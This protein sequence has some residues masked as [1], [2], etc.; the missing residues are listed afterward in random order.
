MDTW[1]PSTCPHPNEGNNT[2]LRPSRRPWRWKHWRTLVAGVPPPKTP[3][4]FLVLTSCCV[5]SGQLLGC[6]HVCE[7]KW[8]SGKE[9]V[10]CINVN[11][12]SI[13]QKLDAGT[14]VL[15]LTGN[16]LHTI[17]R[18]AFHDAGLINLQKVYL[19]KCRLKTLDRYAFRKLINLVELD[20]SYNLLAAVPSHIFDSISELRELKLSGNPIQRILN[21]AFIHVPQL[22]RLEL[23]SCRI[24]TI[25]PRAFNGLEHTL[26]WLK[27][28]H[29]RLVDMKPGTV[30]AMRNLHGLELAGNLWNCTC[31][32]RPLREWMLR[33]NIPYDVPPVCRYPSRLAEKAWDKLDLDEFAC[34]PK[35][36]AP[37]SLTTGVEGRNVTM[38]CEIGGIPEPKVKWL[39][40]NRV[41]ANLSTGVPY[42]GGR[43]LYM[44]HVAEKES[45]LTILTA[46]IQDEGM[47]VCTA[48]NK[49]GKA[50]ASVTLAVL[51]RPPEGSV[52]GKVLVAS[53]IVAA[54]FVL[55]SCLVVLCVCGV[56]RRQQAQGGMVVGSS[57]LVR[58]G[59]GRGRD[60]SYEKIEMNHKAPTVLN[61]TGVNEGAGRCGSLPR[62]GGSNSHLGPGSNSEVAVVGP[63]MVMRQH[64]RHSEYRGVPSVDTDVGDGDGDDEDEEGEDDVDTPTPTTVL[65]GARESKLWGGVRSSTDSGCS[66]RNSE[67]SDIRSPCLPETDLHIPRISEYVDRRDDLAASRTVTGNGLSSLGRQRLEA[68]NPRALHEVTTSTGVSSISCTATLRP[69]DL[70]SPP[71]L[72]HHVMRKQAVGNNGGS[73]YTS[74]LP[75][76]DNTHPDKNYP[77]LLEISPYNLGSASGASANVGGASINMTDGSFCTLPRRRG[78]FE[79]AGVRGSARYYRGAGSDSQ[80]PLLPDSRYGSSGGEGSGGSNGSIRR[81]SIDSYSSS[82]YPLST[83]GTVHKR[84]GIASQRS[85][86]SLNLASPGA[87]SV[88]MESS[89]GIPSRSRKNPSLPTS[90]VHEH[91]QVSTPTTSAT[92]LLNLMGS[93]TRAGDLLRDNLYS[94]PTTVSSAN[95]NTYDYHAAQLERFLEEYRSLQEQLCKMKETCEN[96]RQDPPSSRHPPSS[97]S[98]YTDPLLFGGDNVSTPSGSEDSNNPK[99]ILKNKSSTVAVTATSASS[100]MGGA[101]PGATSPLGLTSGGAVDYGTDLPPYWLPRN[102]LLRRF[103]GGDFFQS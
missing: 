17:P 5:V 73:M 80:S 30:T 23:S 38:S 66:N 69:G 37:E 62:N 82:Y 59:P 31:A 60:D 61:H 100:P 34:A 89:V 68:H 36:S 41:I 57:G 90:P 20:L 27:L 76:N 33:Q 71:G 53:I 102:P 7:C 56:R 8:K 9:S 19:A 79:R 22:V 65:P 91:P 51:R 70:T 88:S 85:S 50:E 93:G 49:A 3:L 2:L 25:E 40:R 75:E 103:S 67:G 4:L 74:E 97:I 84:T 44:V 12:T 15:D 11:L 95:A 78:G 35:I 29:N 77:D 45:N 24:G 72:P 26:E 46:D 98:R 28:D 47:Y 14:Q 54:L 81:S 6:P 96:I 48:E 94:T 52:S 58:G 21:D 83:T 63:H 101:I 10:T 86:S 18:D 64:P 99:S 55:A 1:P 87:S 43:K 39:W 32:I 42:S 13:P 16:S 92:P